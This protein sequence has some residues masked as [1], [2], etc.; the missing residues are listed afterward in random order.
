MVRYTP[1]GCEQEKLLVTRVSML[2]AELLPRVA[3]WPSIHRCPQHSKPFGRPQVHR[4]RGA[5]CKPGIPRLLTA[6]SAP[7]RL[8]NTV[9]RTETAFDWYTRALTRVHQY[10]AQAAAVAAPPLQRGQI[11]DGVGLTDAPLRSLYPD[12][13]TLPKVTPRP[14]LCTMLSMIVQACLVP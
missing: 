12:V 3:G 7:S 2:S 13:P 14:V 4:F 11:D 9:K 1:V 8:S 6:L 5:R 10:A